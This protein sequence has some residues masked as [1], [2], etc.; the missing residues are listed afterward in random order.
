MSGL[1]S[2]SNVRFRTFCFW[3]LSY[4]WAGWAGSGRLGRSCPRRPQA[5]R[6][7][8]LRGKL[9]LGLRLFVRGSVRMEASDLA[10]T[11]EQGDGAVEIFEHADGALGEV[12]PVPVGRNL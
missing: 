5:R 11:V 3:L 9:F 1:G 10:R 12:M 7:A 2:S 8:D 4:L 6:E